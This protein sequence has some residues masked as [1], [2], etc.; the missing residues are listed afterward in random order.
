MQIFPQLPGQAF[1]SKKTQRWDVKAQKSGSK[2]RKAMTSQV[3][4]EWEIEVAYKALSKEN[5]DKI[6][7]F[8]GAMKGP[9][10]PFLWRDLE[11]YREENIRLGIG[12]GMTSGFYLIRN[13]GGYFADRVF[14]VVSGTLKVY[15]NGTLA[16]YTTGDAGLIMLT[17]TPEAG[18]VISADFEYYWRV[19]FADEYTESVNIFYDLYENKKIRLVTIE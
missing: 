1:G 18:D 10:T 17:K 6:M 3:Y 12:D 4:P 16:E 9:L 19:C 15:V 11:D 2:K 14:D 7:G 5:I 13:V 8:Y